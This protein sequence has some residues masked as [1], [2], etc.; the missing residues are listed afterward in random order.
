VRR[1]FA[2]R[3]LDRAWFVV[4]AATPAVN[5]QVAIAAEARRLFINAVDDPANASA[6]AGGVFRRHGVTVAVSTD[7]RAP[8]LAG[9]LREGFEAV[10]PDDDLESWVREAG[11]IRQKWL[12]AGVPMERRRPLLLDALNRLYDGRS[13]EQS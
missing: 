5:R 2:D 10:L 4:A 11:S 8:A 9:L 12:D 13:G 7:G 6:Y 3:D 1:S